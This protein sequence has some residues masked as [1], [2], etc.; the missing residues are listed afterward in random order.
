[1]RKGGHT[2]CWFDSLHFVKCKTFL[3]ESQRLPQLYS[4]YLPWTFAHCFTDHCIQLAR[5]HFFFISFNFIFHLF[6]SRWSVIQLDRLRKR[7]QTWSRHYN[8]RASITNQVFVHRC[9]RHSQLSKRCQ[10]A[11]WESV[12]SCLATNNH[13]CF[14]WGI[15]FRALPNWRWVAIF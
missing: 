10:K 3:L 11:S 6:C 13:L 14:H 7:D 15:F 9:H 1:M 2:K 12:S 8:H 4:L 5:I